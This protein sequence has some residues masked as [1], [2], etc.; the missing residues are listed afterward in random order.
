MYTSRPIL[1]SCRSFSFCNASDIIYFV[2]YRYY[3]LSLSPPRAQMPWKST[4]RFDFSVAF[5][6]YASFTRAELHEFLLTYIC[7]FYYTVLNQLCFL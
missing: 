3:V 1:T 5:R 7:V 6:T 2:R 4:L